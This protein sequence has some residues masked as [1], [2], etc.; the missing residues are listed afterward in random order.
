MFDSHCHLHDDRMAA[1]RDAALQRARRAGI[2][3][4]LLAG[5]DPAGWQVQ[6]ALCAQHPDVLPAYGVHPQVVAESTPDQVDD[7]LRQLE[8]ALTK[9]PRSAAAVAL[10][11]TGLDALTDPRRAAL[12]LQE[13][14]FASQLALCRRY[15]LPVMLHILRAHDRALQ[16]LRRAAPLPDGGV[17]HSYS[18]PAELVPR[19]LD[20]GLHLSFAGAVTYPGARKV[21][22]AVRAVPLDRL[23]IETDAPDQT[24]HPQRARGL[25][26]EPA[27]LVE[28]AAQVATIRGEPVALIQRHTTDNARRLLRLPST[29]EEP[30]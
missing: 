30:S 18:G 29:T 4:F 16:I 12:D 3:G 21:Q 24:P 23:L 9:P 7:M 8:A 2:R 25:Q 19:Y 20:L 1:V 5:V 6:A 11:E 22:A 14:A 17:V 27:F 10:G 15:R 13:R 28:I 26:N